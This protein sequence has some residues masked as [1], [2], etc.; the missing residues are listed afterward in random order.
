VLGVVSEQL[1]ALVEAI[2]SEQQREKRSRP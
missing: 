2:Q 1:S